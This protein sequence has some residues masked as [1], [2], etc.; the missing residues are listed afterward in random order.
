MEDQQGM[1]ERLGVD[2][3]VLGD[4]VSSAEVGQ[5]KR[6]K[7]D[8][9]RGRRGTKKIRIKDGEFRR[10]MRSAEEQAR[11]VCPRQAGKGEHW[12][13][14]AGLGWRAVSIWD[15]T[16]PFWKEGLHTQ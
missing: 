9:R 11:L 8:G 16:M 5:E 7:E 1:E 12:P 10:R 3:S 14:R 2:P 4:N 6:E 15:W 13:R